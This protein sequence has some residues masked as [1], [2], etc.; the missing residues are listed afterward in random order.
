[1]ADDDQ[2]PP[3][4]GDLFNL[5]PEPEPAPVVTRH[6]NL[7]S[8]TRAAF[9][10]YDAENPAIYEQLTKYAFEAFRSGRKRIGINMLHE[11]LR[12]YT[13]IE[14]K[15]D[16]F[17]CANNWRPFY[18]RKLMRDYPELVGFF[19]TRKSIADEE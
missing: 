18:S 17:K 4:Q 11:R 19:E 3:A 9:E 1:M 10:A 6:D 12:W 14:A 7:V 2:D 15:N 16:T 13:T 8:A 5:P